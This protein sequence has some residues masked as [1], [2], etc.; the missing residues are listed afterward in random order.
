MK[1]VV[2]GANGRVGRL[3][4]ADAV[5]RGHDVT[6]FVH[7]HDP[8]GEQAHLR[9]TA[10][11]VSDANAVTGALPGADAVISTLGA[12]RRGTGPVLTP[13]LRT[14]TGA[15][16]EQACGGWSCSRAP[17][18]SCRSGATGVQAHKAARRGRPG[19]Q[20]ARGRGRCFAA[21]TC[22]VRAGSRPPRRA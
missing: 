7:T 17:A 3:V 15:M 10:G 13:G 16:T 21:R 22:G 9:V 2:F 4:V 1:L 20:P 12:F 6:A 5:A 11:D 14:I 18:S 8:F 19:W